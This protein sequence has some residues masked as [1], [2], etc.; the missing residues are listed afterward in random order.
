[1]PPIPPLNLNSS[2]SAKSSQ[3]GNVFD[4]GAGWTVNVTESG[5]LALGQSGGSN[6]PNWVMLAALA[7][8]AFFLVKK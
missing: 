3:D 4:F 6:S 7:A 8:V 5:G 1:M 2:S